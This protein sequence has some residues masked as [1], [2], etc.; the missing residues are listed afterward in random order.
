MSAE[1]AKLSAGPAALATAQQSVA[2]FAATSRQNAASLLAPPF[3]K[4]WD[5]L[6]NQSSQ[7]ASLRLTSTMMDLS[8]SSPRTRIHLRSCS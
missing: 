1:L 3:R 4:R 6:E 7:E 5:R 2:K 8:M